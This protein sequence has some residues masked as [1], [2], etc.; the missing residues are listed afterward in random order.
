MSFK[1]NFRKYLDWEYGSK[2]T[3]FALISLCVN[4]AFAVMNCVLAVRE[5]ALWYGALTAYYALLILFRAATVS[6]AQYGK[7]RYGSEG[8]DY[9]A[10]QNKLYLA[11][12]AFLV[13]IE[14]AMCA[15]VTQ[16]VLSKKQV[17]GGQIYAIATAAYAFFKITMAVYHLVKAK[18][19]AD[20]VSQSLRNLNFADACMS[21]VSL[22]VLML[23]VFDEGESGS[24]PVT[25]KASVGFAACAIVSAV[26]IAMIV[27]SLKKIRRKKQ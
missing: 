13:L 11:C 1:E 2:T 8:E 25:V 17:R 10:M 24:F 3:V 23:S 18:K 4:V 5:R 22:T 15:A 16:M 14:L 12:G 7:R 6:A 21:M 26:A 9:E 27:K 20:P 19:Y